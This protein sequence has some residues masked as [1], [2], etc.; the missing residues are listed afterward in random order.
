MS[1]ID[2]PMVFEDLRDGLIATLEANET[3]RFIT[4]S[5]KRQGIDAEQIKGALRTI[6]VFFDAGDYPEKNYVPGNFGHDPVYGIVYEASAA[7][8]MDLTVIE[9]PE[10]TDEQVAAAIIAGKVAE[11]IVDRAIDEMK[12]F[13]TQILLDPPNRDFTLPKN[14]ANNARLSGFKKGSPGKL[15]KLVTLRA[16]ETFT[17]IIEERTTGASVT[18]AEQPVIDITNDQRPIDESAGNSPKSGVTTKQ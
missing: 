11:L 5:Y 3:G 10:S 17:A 15:G 8:T 12:R 18:P 9:D 4:V 13:A 7:S 14:T 2:T 6:Q 1:G 16:T